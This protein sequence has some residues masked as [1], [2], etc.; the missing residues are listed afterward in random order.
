[1]GY[2]LKF[3]VALCRAAD[4]FITVS[5]ISTIDNKSTF[6]TSLMLLMLKQKYSVCIRSKAQQWFGDRRVTS[7]Q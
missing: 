6:F 4:K 1:M 2:F 5:L 7:Q 3:V